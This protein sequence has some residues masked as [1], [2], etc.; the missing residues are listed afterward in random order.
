MGAIHCTARLLV[1]GYNMIGAWPSLVQAK[2]QHGFEA[3]RRDLTE[4]L[5]NYSARKSFDTY[6][7]FDAHSV[8][9]PASQEDITDN[10]SVCYT[11][12]G[13]TA[14]TYI[15]KICSRLMH[16]SRRNNRIIVATSDRAH[17]LTVVGYGAEWMSAKQLASDV[18]LAQ[19]H[20]RSRPHRPNR[21]GHRSLLRGLDHEAREK[22]NKLR[23]GLR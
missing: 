2:Q 12:F 11:N 20:N 4:I 19:L 21:Q 14:D 3:A 17:Q 16:S 23:F 22:L 1:D 8:R 13:Q 18:Q 10:L 6:L 7:V 9:S 5:A 15:E